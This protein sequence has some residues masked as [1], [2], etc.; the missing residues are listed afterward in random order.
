MQLPQAARRHY[1]NTSR[2]NGFEFQDKCLSK[3]H[4]LPKIGLDLAPSSEAFREPFTP[5]PSRSP[6]Y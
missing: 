2:T 4:P 1:P 3:A 6:Y 5:D